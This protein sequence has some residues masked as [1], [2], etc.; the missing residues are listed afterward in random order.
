MGILISNLA[1]EKG[2]AKQRRPLDSAIFAEL[3]LKSNFS[4]SPDLEQRTFFD[5]VALG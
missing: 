5:L 1:K 2:I 3:C 4:H